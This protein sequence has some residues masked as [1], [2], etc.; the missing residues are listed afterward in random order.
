LIGGQPQIFN[1]SSG[2]FED[3]RM[4]MTAICHMVRRSQVQIEDRVR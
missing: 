2:E 4:F 1:Q 3:A